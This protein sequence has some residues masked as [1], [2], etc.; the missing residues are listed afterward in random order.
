MRFYM[1]DDMRLKVWNSKNFQ[2]KIILDNLFQGKN[3][4]N[5]TMKWKQTKNQLTLLK[6]RKTKYIPYKPKKKA[7]KI[8]DKA[9]KFLSW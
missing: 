3:F 8:S 9:I 4:H 6:Q 5:E 7:K 1:Y 2:G